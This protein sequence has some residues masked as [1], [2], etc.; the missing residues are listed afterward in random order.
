MEPLADLENAYN[1]VEEE[2]INTI[3]HISF[4]LPYND[5]KNQYCRAFNYI[6][7]PGGEL[8][9]IMYN[10]KTINEEGDWEY[11]GEHVLATLVDTLMIGDVI[12]GGAGTVGRTDAV[13]RQILSRQ[14]I[15]N[16]VLGECDFRFNFEYGWTDESLLAAVL[17]VPHHFLAPFMWTFDT[18]SF[19]FVLNLKEL[20][21][22]AVPDLYIEQGK[23]RIKA[24]K[25]Q[26]Q[27]TV[28]TRL[29]PYGY[30]EGVNRLTIS[31][32]N[33]GVD[34]LQSP[35]E[36]FRLYPNAIERTFVDRR[37]QNPRS[38]ME[39]G[40]SILNEAQEPF[41]EYE[42]ELSQLD[43]DP[44]STPAIGKL[45]EI[46]GFKKT[47]ITG[48]R[49]EHKEIPKCTLTLANKTR[50]IANEVLQLRNRQ[51]IEATYAQGVTQFWQNHHAENATQT[52][53]AYMPLFIPGSMR[54]VNFV[55]LNVEVRPFEINVANRATEQP[56]INSTGLMTR[57][58]NTGS[59]HVRL[60][61][62]PSI[63]DQ[64]SLGI[65]NPGSLGTWSA[66]TLGTWNPGSLGTWNAGS[67]PS[68][69][70]QGL[71]SLTLP[72]SLSL[73]GEITRQYTHGG[74]MSNQ[75]GSWFGNDKFLL[76][77]MNSLEIRHTLYIPRDLISWN[78]GSLGTWN[79]GSAPSLSGRRLPSLSDRSLPNLANR[80]LPSLTGRRLP[81]L[82]PS[83]ATLRYENVD[84]G[85]HH[86]TLTNHQHHMPHT[87]LLEAG[88]T[89]VG[90]PTSFTIR[91]NN[92]DRRVVQGRTFRDEIQQWMVAQNGEIN[93][94]FLHRI[95]I[96]PN[97]PA[98]V[99]I[100]VFVQGF[101]MAERELVL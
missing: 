41:E 73:G 72:E 31:S 45:A 58:H 85:N 3:S 61:F 90:N 91:I 79:A 51:R 54:V 101:L 63:F 46:V 98:Y 64:G 67:V 36:I 60:T 22:N 97:V 12:L 65:W 95:E 17:D 4:S 28:C 26:D 82:T 14:P 99:L 27:T 11:R 93:T 39:I 37:I 89:P 83:S 9:R 77:R 59:H 78:P 2:K 48:I 53:A 55:T 6:R 94:N 34:F 13:I 32:V 42:V 75:E 74:I 7:N 40:Q 69:S 50:D 33:N 86:H 70:G 43:G 16:W 44:F 10:G 47:F 76:E 35:P 92:A 25:R 5:H 66:G 52:R 57:E 80:S 20:H 68:L 19:P 24:T 81:S 8:Y 84:T 1:I 15:R 38:L 71:P 21:P 100:T 56:N 30:G 49:W 23:N 29:Y 96:R 62:T 87:H 88:I 18:S